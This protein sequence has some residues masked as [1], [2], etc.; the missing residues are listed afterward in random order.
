MVARKWTQAD[1]AREAG[2]S[3]DAI[4]RYVSGKTGVSKMNAEKMAVAL[5]MTVDD[6]MTACTEA[7]EP[8]EFEA[9]EGA[10]APAGAIRLQV[11][12]FVPYAVAV[13]ILTL[14][15]RQHAACR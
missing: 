12:Q 11:D 4:S 8:H 15:Q 13:K 7:G 1:F 10:P 3:D 9:P 5:G 14:L 2:V 6:M